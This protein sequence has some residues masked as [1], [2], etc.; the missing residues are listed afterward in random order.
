MYDVKVAYEL[1]K[2]D[3]TIDCD[4]KFINFPLET[5]ILSVELRGNTPELCINYMAPKESF[6]I[7]TSKQIHFIICKCE[8]AKDVLAKYRY[9]SN[10][11]LNRKKFAVF[12]N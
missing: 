4:H 9:L 11:T 7:D 5:E 10:I 3:P 1:L 12:C 8:F 6:E 2:F